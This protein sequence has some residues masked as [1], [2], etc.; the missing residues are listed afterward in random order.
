M[1]YAKY[2]LRR[3]R[4]SKMSYTTLFIGFILFFSSFIFFH[5]GMRMLGSLLFYITIILIIIAM[6]LFIIGEVK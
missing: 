1:N 4:A 3:K 5:L 6:I 2:E